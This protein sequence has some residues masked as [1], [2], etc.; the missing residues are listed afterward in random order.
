MHER[1]KKGGQRKDKKTARM[2]E[3]ENA[4]AAEKAAAKDAIKFDTDQKDVV[5]YK[6]GS[7]GDKGVDP[8]VRH[9]QG[10]PRR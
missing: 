7:R 1:K 6:Q 10:A 4:N 2:H 9:S 8:T 5:T 3:H